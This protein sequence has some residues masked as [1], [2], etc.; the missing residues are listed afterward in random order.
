MKRVLIL[1]YGAT[2][3]L[4]FLA[5]FAYLCAFV[6]DFRFLVPKTMDSGPIG[7][8]GEALL[9]NAA[10]IALFGVQHTVMARPGFKRWL[11]RFIPRAAERSTYVLLSSLCLIALVVLWRPIGGTVWHV[12]DPVAR[13]VLYGL[14]GLGWAMIVYVTFLL[15]HFDLFGLRQAWLAFR[16]RDY[17]HLPFREPHL[18][19][20]IRH[21]LYVGWLCAFWFTPTM[22]VAHL[23]FAVLQTV[24]ILIAIRYEE[25]DLIAYL[26]GYQAYRERV[27]MLVPRLRR[28]REPGAV[29]T[30]ARG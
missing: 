20:A 18:Y 29:L 28:R 3:Y 17:T 27:P 5:T 15:N 22:T 21:P 16:G 6:G 11:T 10:L 4:L 12:A 7:P 26:P 13:G 23:F 14:F 2:A 25:R 8:L 24:Y 30:A 1:A 19:R 9:V